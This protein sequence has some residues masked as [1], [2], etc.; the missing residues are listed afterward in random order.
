MRSMIE[1]RQ[2]RRGWHTVAQL[3]CAILAFGC[4]SSSSTGTSGTNGDGGGGAGVRDSGVG[5]GA[6]GAGGASSGDP[7]AAGI[8]SGEAFDAGCR[9]DVSLKAV[10]FGK[11]PPFDVVIVA[12]NS[13][14][15]S[16]SR[17]DLSSGLAN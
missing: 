17:D 9:R 4:D 7:D 11:P 13:D 8:S 3:G 15:L 14:S 16:W 5:A 1:G 12:D 10:T 2:K 6:A